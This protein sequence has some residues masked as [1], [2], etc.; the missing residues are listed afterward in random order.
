MATEKRDREEEKEE[1]VNLARKGI[2]GDHVVL[3][4]EV[5]PRHRRHGGASEE[6]RQSHAQHQPHRLAPLRLRSRLRRSE[7]ASLS[8]EL[9][10]SLCFAPT[11]DACKVFDLWSLRRIPGKGSI[12]ACLSLYAWVCRVNATWM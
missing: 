5:E 6:R 12:Y 8:T 11:T 7:R 3:V 10:R 9:V 1:E 4:E 2:V